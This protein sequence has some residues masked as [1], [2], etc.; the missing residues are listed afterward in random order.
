MKSLLTHLLLLLICST[1]LAVDPVKDPLVVTSLK[2]S[3][4]LLTSQPQDVKFQ[5]KLPSGYYVYVD[6]FQVAAAG[7]PPL[8]VHKFEVGPQVK[9]FDKFTKK[10]RMGIKETGELN[11]TVSSAI[12][13]DDRQIQITYQACSPDFC[14][15]PTKKLIHLSTA[16]IPKAD[17]SL[18]DY[19]SSISVEDL[20]SEGSILTFLFIFF[21]GILTSFTPC[22]FPMIPITLSILG[23]QTIGKS[24]WKGF[25]LSL[26]YVH[27]IAT[28]YSILGVAAAKSGT[29][30]GAYLSSPVV[31]TF[32]ALIF[33]AMALSMFGLYEIQIP[34]TIRSK[35]G[36]KK[37]SQGNV[38]AYISGLVAGIVASPCVGPV[39]V[40]LLTYVAQT[41]KAVLGF[42]Y[43]FTYAMGL[44]LIFI[45]LGTFSQF[46]SKLPRSGPW[47]TRVKK[48]FGVILILM[49]FY[50]IYPVAKSY[51]KPPSIENLSQNQTGWQPYSEELLKSAVNKQVV[52]IDF[53]A[54][55][56]AACKELDKFTFGNLEVKRKMA[57]ALLLKVDATQENNFVTPILNK[58]GIVGLPTIIFIET[59]GTIRK[60]L[61]LTGFEPPLDFI[62]RFDKLRT[63]Q[64]L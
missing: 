58:Y 7:K 5:L 20:I 56:C 35:L 23:S 22:I 62:K 29:L 33:F 15:L 16:N 11:V 49:G 54:D 14:L 48:I 52:I 10:E 12:K 59:D 51:L 43:L 47:M 3:D 8:K 25:V 44:G 28:T 24:R 6:S 41:Q 17:E 30:F 32:I 63:K 50:Y 60:D 55:W 34:V 2:E 4:I 37:I 18:A 39:L 13:I 1:T 9:F 19:L 38:G 61:T 31:V 21:A 64:D 45:V 36:N 53:Y 27:G 46:M 42:F 26:F 57:G 40:A